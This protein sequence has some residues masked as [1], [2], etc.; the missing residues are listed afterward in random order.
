MQA[1]H[2]GGIQ[3]LTPTRG[4]V[5]DMP[6]ADHSF[7]VVTMLEVLEHIPNTQRTLAEICRVASR[8]IVLSVPSKE[9]NNPEHIHLFD[10]QSI[11]NPLKKH[12]ITPLTT[13]SVL[14]HLSIFAI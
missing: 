2:D 6:F 4:D 14:N 1:V 11:K 10:Q 13:N 5:T 3:Q 8:F 9:D 7:D 12:A